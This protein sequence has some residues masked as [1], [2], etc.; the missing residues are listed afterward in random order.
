M[1]TFGEGG[2]KGNQYAKKLTT[3]ELRKAAYDS[4][5]AHFADGQSRDTWCFEH[6]DLDLTA[7]TMDKY[8][9]ENPLEFPPS[10]LEKA[11]AKG[12]LI[13]E[14]VVQESANGKNR[15][16]NTASLQMWMRNRFKWDRPDL[17]TECND[18]TSAQAQDK[19]MNQLANQQQQSAVQATPSNE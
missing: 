7:K 6:P 4:Y 18:N 5:C 13:W 3:P 11:H 12:Q 15:K 14:R 2:P 1:G 8:I 10:Q 17:R 19:L 16:A 9:R